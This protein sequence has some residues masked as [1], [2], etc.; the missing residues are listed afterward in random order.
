MG[1]H[2]F[3]CPPVHDVIMVSTQA[4][5]EWILHL[6]YILLMVLPAFNHVDGILSLAGG[7]SSYSEGSSGCCTPEGGTCLDVAAGE[8]VSGT[9]TVGSMSWLD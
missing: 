4:D 8:T 1:R 6:S 7:C 5:V 3:L 9:V 2:W